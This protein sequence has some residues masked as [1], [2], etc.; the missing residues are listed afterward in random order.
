MKRIKSVLWF[1]A[2]SISLFANATK[3]QLEFNDVDN[4]VVYQSLIKEITYKGYITLF[5]LALAIILVIVFLATN[6]RMNVTKFWYKYPMSK[7][8][9]LQLF[10][11]SIVVILYFAIK[12]LPEAVQYITTPE[13]VIYKY[14]I[15]K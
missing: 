3:L 7:F 1:L 8:M 10:V 13:T 12:D 5:E 11:M 2:I 9:I 4:N 15:Q 6:I 14:L